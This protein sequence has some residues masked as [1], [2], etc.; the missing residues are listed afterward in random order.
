MQS[1]Q[2]VSDVASDEAWL[3]FYA[4]EAF[5]DIASVNS[6]TCA[7]TLTPPPDEARCVRAHSDANHVAA[8]SACLHSTVKIE[9]AEPS[10]PETSTNP[11]AASETTCAKSTVLAVV[12]TESSEVEIQGKKPSRCKSS[13]RK[14][15]TREEEDL[16]LQGLDRFGPIDVETDPVTGRVSVRLGSVSYEC[17]VSNVLKLSI[18]LKQFDHHQTVCLN[19]HCR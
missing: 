17:L 12:L 3:K 18:R 11:N 8:D 16:F 19:T 4:T 7:R 2:C 14:P 15:W 13:A 5:E 6:K 10:V 1:A 9:P